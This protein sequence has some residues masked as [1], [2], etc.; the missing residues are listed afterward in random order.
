MTIFAGIVARRGAGSPIPAAAL[1]A[2]A[3]NLNR[4]P[5]GRPRLWQGPSHAIATCELGVPDAA[6]VRVEDGSITVVGGDPLID[7]GAAPRSKEGE[8]GRLHAQWR[9]RETLDLRHTRG[10][11]CGV[12]FDSAQHRLW[13]V[14]D[15]LALRPIY[16]A[17]LDDWIVFANAM[18]VL[19]ACPL[20]PR[21][22][23]LR[24][25][26]ET[27]S[28]GFALGSRTVLAAASALEPGRIIEASPQGMTTIEY[29]RWDNLPQS[30]AGADEMCARIQQ[31]FMD[32]VRI[33]LGGNPRAAALLS[34]GLDSRSVVGALRAL[35][36]E[37]HTI[38][39]GPEGSA[40]QVI[41][42]QASA[43]LGTT[44]FEL[45]R[46]VT[47][48]WSRMNEAHGDWLV[49]TGAS[50]PAAQAHTLWSG[51]GGDRVLAPVNLNEDV[52]DAMRAGDPEAAITAYVGYER[53]ALPR[54][55]FRRRVRDA[56][57]RLPVAGVRAEL[58]GYRHEDGGRRFHL[59][60]LCNES[61][62]NIKQHFE[63]VDLSRVELVMPFYD[64][65]L[66]GAALRYP[67]DPFVRHRLYHR[68]LTHQ[69]AAVASVPWQGY[70]GSQPCPLPLPAGIVPQ[71]QRWY[72][73]DE[74]RDIWCSQVELADRLVSARPFPDWI[75][76]R[77]V[78]RVARM[79][80]RA[81]ARGYGYLFEVARP[82]VLYPTQAGAPPPEN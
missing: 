61:R 16:Y 2:L 20:V 71:W 55:I 52:I 73:E 17:V 59:Y 10:S 45:V 28:L 56:I 39:F 35:G 54:R 69:P 22:G 57:R 31:T 78:L 37:V 3:D 60:V 76:R 19:E 62:K 74:D 26:V 41:A 23:D 50:W 75:I 5:Q 82:F 80:L 48:F 25:L 81:G 33:R 18:R 30:A 53:T 36:A 11:F 8:V 49:G 38:G 21:T 42:R 40:D 4:H 77:W 14:P 27:A 68:W 64:P 13:L 32:S 51:E 7:A 34:G 65:E 58:E 63:D 67:L 72:T 44:H 24:G 9:M 6:A 1:R 70:P 43:A 79:L 12:H 15:K 29:W 66:L 46:R 47:G